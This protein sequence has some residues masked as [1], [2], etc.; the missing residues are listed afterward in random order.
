MSATTGNFIEGGEVDPFRATAQPLTLAE[1]AAMEEAKRL[2]R[3]EE[4]SRQTAAV[5]SRPGGFNSSR[6]AVTTGGINPATGKEWTGRER[7]D[8]DNSVGGILT[9]GGELVAEHPWVLGMP[10]APLAG[11]AFAPGAVGAGTLS[12]PAAAAPAITT[13]GA[14][15]E[16]TI[17][18][19]VATGAATGTTTAAAAAPAAAP[20]A[21]APFTVGG[22]IKEVAPIIGGV[23][24]FAIDEI[25][26]GNT[27]E[28]DALVAKQRQ[29]AKEAEE[30]RR[31]AQESRMNALGQQ[32]LAMNPSNQMMARMFGPDAAF[33]PEQMAAMTQNPMPPPAMP[34]ELKALEGKNTKNTPQQAAA[35]RKYQQELQQYEEGNRRRSEQMMNGITPPGPGPAPL[36]PRTPQPARKY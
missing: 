36:Q 25:W 6:T 12:A 32:L 29:M 23:A 7:P 19:P 3:L 27:K 8:V 26:G 24:P 35:F 33:Q 34:P 13:G 1:Q 21:A 30:H 20:A 9:R 14:V 18:A 31:E 28:Q 17:A 22:A 5:N 15:T 16:A 2:R 4:R 11:A 10:L